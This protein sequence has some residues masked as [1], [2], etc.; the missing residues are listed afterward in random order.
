M[1]LSAKESSW[2]PAVPD[3]V[4]KRLAAGVGFSS[5]RCLLPCL[6]A[7]SRPIIMGADAGEVGLESD[8]L[9]IEH[10]LDAVGKD[11][12]D[13]GRVLFRKQMN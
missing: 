11:E 5:L 1:V 6:P 2:I 9:E 8:G 12:G 7:S 3:M 4:R 13:A 10:Q